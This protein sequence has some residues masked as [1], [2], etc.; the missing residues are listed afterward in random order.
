[1]ILAK[2]RSG[3]THKISSGHGSVKTSKEKLVEKSDTT[4]EVECALSCRTCEEENEQFPA[5]G[6]ALSDTRS[7]VEESGPKKKEAET[8]EFEPWQHASKSGSWKL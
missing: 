5:T 1:M 3:A 6:T 2:V 7:T 8:F 4:S